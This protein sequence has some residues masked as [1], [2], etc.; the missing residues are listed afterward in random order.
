MSAH[1]TFLELLTI[2]LTI[3]HV[4]VFVVVKRKKYVQYLLPMKNN[5]NIKNPARYIIFVMIISMT[6]RN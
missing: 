3:T 2:P 1:L 5:S 4:K 6:L